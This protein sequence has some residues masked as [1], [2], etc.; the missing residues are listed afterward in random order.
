VS[1]EVQIFKPAKRNEGRNGKIYTAWAFGATQEAIAEEF[2]MSV[3]NVKRILEQVKA[4]SPQVARDELRDRLTEAALLMSRSALEIYDQPAP[5]IVDQKGGLVRDPE[6]GLVARDYSQKI[7]AGEFWLRICDRLSK[8]AGADMP[9][10]TI[11]DHNVTVATQEQAEG[12]VT[13]FEHLR[14]IAS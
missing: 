13:R 14:V 1:E 11:V 10:Q 7:K 2:H 5:P 9:Q 6:T 3:S 4:H 12:V 8:L